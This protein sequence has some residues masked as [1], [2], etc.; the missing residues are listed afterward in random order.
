M[1]LKKVAMRLKPPQKAREQKR[2]SLWESQGAEAWSL[3]L[4][5]GF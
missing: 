1:R 5:V 2:E 3:I 4:R